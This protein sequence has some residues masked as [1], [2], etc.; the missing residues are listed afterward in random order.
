MGAPTPVQKTKSAKAK[1]P[2]KPRGTKRRGNNALTPEDRAAKAAAAAEREAERAA[3]RA[4]RA[5]AKSAANAERGSRGQYLCTRCGRPKAGHICDFVLGRAVATQVQLD[6]TRGNR[7][8]ADANPE[9]NVLIADAGGFR[10]RTATNV[11]KIDTVANAAAAIAAAASATAESSSDSSRSDS[12]NSS[13]DL[14]PSPSPITPHPLNVDNGMP[15]QQ[16]RQSLMAPQVQVPMP[17]SAAQMDIGEE[18]KSPVR[19]AE[20]QQRHLVRVIA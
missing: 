9:C 2:P 11:I 8:A 19:A 15:L 1:Q 17:N 18:K 6:V 20:A 5:K 7:D 4:A 16:K 14:G 13:P 12:A 3:Q 10:Q